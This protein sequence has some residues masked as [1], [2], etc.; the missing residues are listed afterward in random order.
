[1]SHSSVLRFTAILGLLFG[2][3]LLLAPDALMAIYGSRPLNTTGAYN[4]MLYGAM[5]IGFSVLDWGASRMPA[6]QVRP[7]LLGNLVGSALGLA[8]ALYRQLTVEGSPPAAW[9]N[10]VL[11]LALAGLFARLLAG[12][13]DA[14]HARG[15]P[16]R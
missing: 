14:V 3:P 6:G 10:V 8:V 4:T 13:S 2:F 1:M 11:F 7:V 16:A 12:S 5:M 15:E 9:I